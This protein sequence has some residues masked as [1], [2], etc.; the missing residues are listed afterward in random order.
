MSKTIIVRIQS[1]EGTK[2]INVSP[3]SSC[4]KLLRKVADELQL[5]KDGFNLYKNRNKTQELTSSSSSRQTISS[6]QIR[7]GDM[8]YL[9]PNVRGASAMETEDAGTGEAGVTA[10]PG[11]VEED[12]VDVLLA[13]EDGRI[14]RKRDQQF[15]HHNE[16][17]KCVHCVPLEPYDEKYMMMQDPPIK[18]MSFHTYIRKL[19]G[20]ADKGKFI[21]LENLSCKIKTNCPT[22]HA[23]W[24][25]GICTNCQ[26]SPVTLD[27]QMYRHVDNVMFEN[28][29]VIDHFLEYWRKTGFQR[30]GYMLGRYDIH[31]DVPLGIK[32]IVSTIYEPPQ[33]A[34]ANSVELLLDPKNETLDRIANKLGL[35]KVG[36]IFTDLIPED[37]NKGT[38]KHTRNMDAHFLS[39]E[40]CIMAANFQNQYSNPCNAA[41]DR[42]FGSKFV[43]C[44]ITGDVDNQIH[45]ECYQVSNQC[46]ALV[47]DNCLIP[48]KDAPELGYIRESTQEQYVPDVFYNEKD[49]YGNVLKKLARPLP[50][51]FL[52]LDVP[53]G[54]SKD[55]IYAFNGRN[56]ANHFPIENRSDIGEIQDL[57]SLS[58]YMKQFPSSEF[59]QAMSDFHLLIYL[60][61]FEMFPLKEHMELLLD[62]MKTQD[63]RLADEWS[64]GEHWST[65]QHFMAAQAP[66]PTFTSAPVD[67][68]DESASSSATWSCQAC[69]FINSGNRMACELCEGPRQ[70]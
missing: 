14:Y 18:H 68:S 30:I 5:P 44:I 16:N 48:T 1:P 22:G 10:A 49:S 15:C 45:P 42:Y 24:P 32:A 51:E 9:F 58:K 20:G 34:T 19:K 65:L 4:S 56:A 11:E 21:N 25:E 61:T 17:S 23:P 26:P 54:F 2:R 55:P 31:K 43:T 57:S 63:K 39:A 36:W 6:F 41:T 59:L 66:S 40:E 64:K 47:R 27:R 62:A 53:S 50:V 13:K 60:A 33:R 35:R 29:S 3:S 67:V 46:M 70:P 8:L 69:T 28:G 7:N 12:E 38:V 52:L 37:L